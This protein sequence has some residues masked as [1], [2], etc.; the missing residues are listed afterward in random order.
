MGNVTAIARNTVRQAFRMKVLA[1]LGLFVFVAFLILLVSVK[2]YGSPK[3]E[4]QVLLTYSLELAT[5]LL[6]VLTVFLSTWTMCGEI[7]DRQIF[8]LDTK[9]VHRWQILAGKWLGLV[10]VNAIL[11]VAMALPTY[12]LVWWQVRGM[13]A[14]DRAETREGLLVGRRGVRPG[15][16]DIGG[17]I[18]T[19]YERRKREGALPDGASLEHIAEE[20]QHAVYQRH[21]TINHGFVKTWDFGDLPS[22]ADFRQGEFLT[23]RFRF[24]AA[25][26][27]VQQQRVGQ[28]KVGHSR[29]RRIVMGPFNHKATSNMVQEFRIPV[30]ALPGKGALL[31][32]Y[33]NVDPTRELVVFP[34]EGGIELLYPTLSFTQNFVN[35]CLL[36]LSRIAFLAALGLTCSTFLTFPMALTVCL[37]GWIL[38]TI[39]NYMLE[40]AGHTLLISITHERLS[41]GPGW[42]DELFRHY[43]KALFSMVP[44]FARYNPV[45]LLTDGREVGFSFVGA[46]LLFLV[47]LRGGLIALIGAVVFQTRE[48]AKLAR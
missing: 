33:T 8:S 27:L 26:P 22:P 47:L 19:E 36:I 37:T 18:K 46:C 39:S 9:P 28:W 25:N 7:Q 10:V 44:D 23:L 12:G 4:L 31:V 20:I 13:E 41:E 11:L 48:L 43:L 6:S 3:A 24:Y 15:L 14:K 32:S 29:D 30:E 16:P 21:Q 2:S 34:L 5:L 17:E 35:S 42:L 40:I 1:V 38:C 45:P